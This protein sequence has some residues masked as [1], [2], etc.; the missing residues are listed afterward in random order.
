MVALK[1]EM[2]CRPDCMKL[3]RMNNREYDVVVGEARLNLKSSGDQENFSVL[4]DGWKCSQDD[5]KE[6]GQES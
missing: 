6:I 4:Y 5:L 1:P 2:W 3:W